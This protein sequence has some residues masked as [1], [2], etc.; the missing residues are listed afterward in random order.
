MNVTGGRV[1]RRLIARPGATTPA[2]TSACK[3]DDAEA[4]YASLGYQHQP[5]F[6]S[7]IAGEWLVNE[8]NQA[9]S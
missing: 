7:A 3:T 4:F 9:G 5:V 2:S 8:A 6:M 1:Q